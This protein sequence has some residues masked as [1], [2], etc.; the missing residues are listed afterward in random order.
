MC[1]S[2]GLCAIAGWSGPRLSVMGTLVVATNQDQ[3]EPGDLVEVQ[4][5]EGGDWT[6]ALVEETVV[7]NDGVT[8]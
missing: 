5:S 3:F 7:G 8:S 4:L 6:N 1:A 2:G